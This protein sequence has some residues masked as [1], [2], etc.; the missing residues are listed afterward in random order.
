VLV[1]GLVVFVCEGQILH[2]VSLDIGL[3]RLWKKAENFGQR[4]TERGG[5][6]RKAIVISEGLQSGQSDGSLHVND[7]RSWIG[8]RKILFSFCN[9]LTSAFG[10]LFFRVDN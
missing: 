1:D 6:D 2:L 7:R 5:E 8:G 3:F 10:R 9:R 4:D